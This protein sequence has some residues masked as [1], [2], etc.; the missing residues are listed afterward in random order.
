MDR[1]DR[2]VSKARPVIRAPPATRWPDHAVKW[3]REATPVIRDHRGRPVHPVLWFAGVWVCKALPV[4]LVNK[5]PWAIPALVV[6]ARWVMPAQ[7]VIKAPSDPT[8]G[9][10]QPEVVV[11]R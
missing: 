3:A 8:G 5:A 2:S 10:D 9:W 4:S 6:K 11:P 7:P 1:L